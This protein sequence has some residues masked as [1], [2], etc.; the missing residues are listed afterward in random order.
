M[1]RGYDQLARDVVTQS[2]PVR[3][4]LDRARAWLVALCCDAQRG[5]ASSF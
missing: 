3:F 5:G 2:L 4:V 1:Q